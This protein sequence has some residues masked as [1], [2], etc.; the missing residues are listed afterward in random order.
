[1]F[2]GHMLV[3][4]N[5]FSCFAMWNSCPKFVPTFHLHSVYITADRCSITYS[6]GGTAMQGNSCECNACNIK[7]FWLRQPD[8]D[9]RTQKHKLLD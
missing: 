4:M 5:I 8:R 6:C 7:L 2:F 3:D 1:M 9:K